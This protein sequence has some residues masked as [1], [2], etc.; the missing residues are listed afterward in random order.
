M[1]LRGLLETVEEMKLTKLERETYEFIRRRGEVMTVNIPPRMRGAVPNLKRKGLIEVYKDYTTPWST[2][3][4]KF[5]RVKDHPNVQELD[6][7]GESETPSF[8]LNQTKP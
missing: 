6:S 2:K 4:M 5:V 3:K 8:D 7:N 1:S